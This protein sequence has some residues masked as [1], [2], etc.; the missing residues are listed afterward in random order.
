[1]PIPWIVAGVVVAGVGGAIAAVA[2]SSDVSDT[3]D[4]QSSKDYIKT[5]EDVKKG[6]QKI[7]VK[8]MKK[9]V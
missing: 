3:S 5:R 7:Q 8:N 6:P 2:T 9:D 1:M 4:S